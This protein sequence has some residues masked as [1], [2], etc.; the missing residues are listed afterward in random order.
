M[1]LRFCGAMELGS[2]TAAPSVQKI[3]ASQHKSG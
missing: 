1:M 3:N 2:I